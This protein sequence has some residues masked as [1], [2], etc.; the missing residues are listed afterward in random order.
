MQGHQEQRKAEKG[1]E[2]LT[3]VNSPSLNG[4][5]KLEEES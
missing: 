3:D 4:G 2:D 1:V 5:W